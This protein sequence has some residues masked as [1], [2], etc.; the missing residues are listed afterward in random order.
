MEVEDDRRSMTAAS[1]ALGKLRALFFVEKSENLSGKS[2]A[3][4]YGKFKENCQ[5]VLTRRLIWLIIR[6]NKTNTAPKEG[7]LIWHFGTQ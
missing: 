5:N 3:Y 6:I 7:R 4:T 2:A 1:T